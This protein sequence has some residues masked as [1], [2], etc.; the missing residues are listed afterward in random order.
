MEVNNQRLAFVG[1]YVPRLLLSFSA[2]RRPAAINTG[3]SAEPHKYIAPSTIDLTMGR[4]LLLIAIF[5]MVAAATNAFTTAP[6]F[7]K[8]TCGGALKFDDEFAD[9]SGF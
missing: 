1:A 4:T 7:A 3:Q 8:C 5:A 6:A 2:F 9:S